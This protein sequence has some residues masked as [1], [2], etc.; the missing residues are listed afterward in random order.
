[1]TPVRLEPATPRSRVKHSTSEPLHSLCL[2]L[3]V[4]LLSFIPDPILQDVCL[5]LSFKG[6]FP[7]L[8]AAYKCLAS[9]IFFASS[10]FK[11]T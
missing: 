3:T 6:P 11:S 4:Q 5:F 7:L 1:M 10:E 2:S 8:S 9:L